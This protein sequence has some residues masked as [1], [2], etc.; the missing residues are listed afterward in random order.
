MVTITT[1]RAT[2]ERWDDV[3]RALTGGGDGASC[4]CAWLTLRAKDWNNTTREERT[5]L[6]HDEITAGPPP[7]LIAY[8][9]G[10]AA[11]WVRVGPRTQQTRLAHTRA[12]A[13]ATDEPLT[14]ESVWAITCFVV[15]REHRG[16]ALTTRLIHDAVAFARD[17]GAR[18]IEGY[19]VDTTTGSHASNDLF[20]G[21]LSTFLAAGFEQRAALKPGRPLVVLELAQTPAS[22][23]V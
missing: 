16:K 2:T 20:H 23:A 12:I 5:A 22:V 1:Q 15:R 7:G 10:E 3:Q 18:L 17:E 8:V 6:L 13:A 4:Q 9:D 11:G 21:T 19:P 14:D